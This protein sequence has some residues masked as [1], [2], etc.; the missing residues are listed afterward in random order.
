MLSRQKQTIEYDVGIGVRFKVTPLVC[1]TDFEQGREASVKRSISH[2]EEFDPE[3]SLQCELLHYGIRKLKMWE[4]VDR[5]TDVSKYS[6]QSKDSSA[7]ANTRPHSKGT[8]L[9]HDNQHSSLQRGTECKHTVAVT[10]CTGKTHS[11]C[12]TQCGSQLP[13]RFKINTN[14]RLQVSEVIRRVS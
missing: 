8:C 2:R 1:T 11:V 7:L 12:S 4:A 13:S 6:R 10:Q 5:K 14:M 9:L 3:I